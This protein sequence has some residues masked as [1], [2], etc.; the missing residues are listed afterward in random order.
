MH[1]MRLVYIVSFLDNHN[2]NGENGVVYSSQA[3]K[4]THSSLRY[5]RRLER[6]V[7]QQRNLEGII[8]ASH[9]LGSRFLMKFPEC[10]VACESAFKCTLHYS[11][12]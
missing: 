3:R 10:P 12:A 2:H 5:S 11:A 8:I 6:E 4:S 1:I 9:S 7:K